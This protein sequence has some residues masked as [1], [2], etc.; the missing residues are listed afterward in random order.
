[1]YVDLLAVGPPA[2]RPVQYRLSGPDIQELRGLAQQ[3]ASLI[4]EHPL[5][6]DIGFNWNEP[7]RVV[8]V[9][10]LQD[11][12]R[13]LGVTSQDIAGALNGVVGGTSITQ[14][15]DSIYLVDVV[16]RASSAERGSIET[17]QNLQLPG[18]NGQS[19]PL[20]AVATFRY[21][22]E[23]PVI[24]RRSRV[25]T[26]TIRGSIV[27]ERSQRRSFSSSNPRCRR[28]SRRCRPATGWPWP[29]QWRRAASRKDQSRRWSRS[30]C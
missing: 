18:R 21:E 4:G 12:A 19:V 9:D 3:L 16:S 27:D 11:K 6:S 24:W 1:M 29:A 22:L 7:A 23:Q 25:P 5:V 20:A 13:Q 17:L 14:V 30:C 10:V 8:K 2:G 15:R 26:I 28:L